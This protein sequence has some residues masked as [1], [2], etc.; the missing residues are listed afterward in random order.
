MA[1]AIHIRRRDPNGQIL[2]I[3][4]S[5]WRA[6]VQQTEN[7]RIAEGD[8]RTG[9]PKTGEIIALRNTGGDAEVFFPAEAEWRRLF[10]WSPSG[11]VSFGAPRDFD[12]PTSDVRRLASKLA[13]ALGASLVGDEGEVYE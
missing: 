1:Y 7:V 4:I 11:Q 13:H 5:E 3:A 12:L 8:F 2:P 10:R 9:N 6:A